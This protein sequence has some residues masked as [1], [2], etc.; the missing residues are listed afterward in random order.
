MISNVMMS[1]IEKLAA[2]GRISADEALDVR[3]AI[4]PDGPSAV[5]TACT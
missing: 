3:R 5:G 1:L 4:F 2:D